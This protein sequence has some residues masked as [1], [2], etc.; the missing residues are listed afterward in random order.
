MK[1]GS[2]TAF[3]CFMDIVELGQFSF[4]GTDFIIS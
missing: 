4:W 1:L 2:E 3:K